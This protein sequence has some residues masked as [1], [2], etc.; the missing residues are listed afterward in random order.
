MFYK[1]KMLVS[2]HGFAATKITSY[3]ASRVGEDKLREWLFERHKGYHTFIVKNIEI[4][5]IAEWMMENN[6]D[7]IEME[8]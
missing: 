3:Y 7:V 1:V 8:G 2:E 5:S 4:A 6:V